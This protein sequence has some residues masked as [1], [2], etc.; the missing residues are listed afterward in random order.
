M[1]ME[2]DP[3]WVKEMMAQHIKGRWPSEV[4]TE[5]VAGGMAWK[6]KG[7]G[8]VGT[9]ECEK[10]CGKDKS[11]G[12]AP[13]PRNKERPRPASEV[14]LDRGGARAIVPRCGSKRVWGVMDSRGL[15]FA[16]GQ[17]W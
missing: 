3:A 4:P 9:E 5:A 10:I 7:C 17:E 14:N 13:W 15:D 2:C 6:C 12:G 16:F 1:V 11:Q 8:I